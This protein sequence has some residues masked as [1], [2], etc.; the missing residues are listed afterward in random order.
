MLPMV[1]E[2]MCFAWVFSIQRFGLTSNSNPRAMIRCGQPK[3]TKQKVAITT[4]AL[5]ETSQRGIMMAE[6]AI[7]NMNMTK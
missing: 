6:K 5:E 4:Y 1:L 3:A 2:G 7:T